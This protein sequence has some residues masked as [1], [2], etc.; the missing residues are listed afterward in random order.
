MYFRKIGI[1]YARMCNKLHS[2]IIYNSK[3]LEALE[4]SC[5]KTTFPTAMTVRKLQ[6]AITGSIYS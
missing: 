5:I 4:A 6:V 2:I 1:V 3:V